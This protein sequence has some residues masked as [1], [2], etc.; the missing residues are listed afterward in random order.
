ML[1]ERLVSSTILL[2]RLLLTDS[3]YLPLGVLIIRFKI[4][5]RPSLKTTVGTHQLIM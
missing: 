4:L 3:P 5:S 1:N 2:L